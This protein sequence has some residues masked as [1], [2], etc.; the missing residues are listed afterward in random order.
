MLLCT[1]NESQTHEGDNQPRCIPAEQSVAPPKL[2]R[3]SYRIPAVRHP[4]RGRH[5]QELRSDHKS[6]RGAIFFRGASLD[7]NHC[8]CLSTPSA[9]RAASWIVLP[10]RDLRLLKTTG[11]S[12]S[13]TDHAQHVNSGAGS[14]DAVLAMIVPSGCGG[15]RSD[16]RAR[17]RIA[18]S[19]S[20]S[21]TYAVT[22]PLKCGHGESGLRSPFSF[23]RCDLRVDRMGEWR[24]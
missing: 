1:R 21:L 7:P 19:S 14:S 22:H 20:T 23:A 8:W 4:R 24:Y 3:I 10:G 6:E 2:P 15:A 12:Q 11:P 17:R 13:E 9:A 16:S 5:S 18:A